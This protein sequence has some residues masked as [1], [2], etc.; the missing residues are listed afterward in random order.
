MS[1]HDELRAF[2]AV[3]EE[4]GFTAAAGVL[5]LSTSVVSRRV[6]SLEEG[7]GVRLLERTTRQVRATSVGLDYHGRVAPLLEALE[8]AARA[9]QDERSEPK[10]ILRVAVPAVFGRA[11]LSPVFASFHQRYPQIRVDASYSDRTVDLHGESADLAIRG[12]AAIDDNLVARKIFDFHGVCVASPEYLARR[13]TPATPEALSDH[14]CL[15]NSGLRT[16]PG[17]LFFRDGQPL[18]VDVDGP[19]R[20]DD[21]LALV[22][23]A[24]AGLG[25][26]YE[27]IFI[28]GPA[29]ARGTVVSIPFSDKPYGG[30][31]FAVYAN[32]RH[33]PMRVRVFIDH[34]LNMWQEPPWQAF[35]DDHGDTA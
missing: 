2:V 27:P 17:W 22:S 4:G 12:G 23:A 26:A 14:D 5:G 15:V 21:G 6:K 8:D 32:R 18:Q 3:V 19:F 16:M 20:C 34:L 9:A 1:S 11:Y 7:L 33:L 31:F 13:G 35:A 28:A 24:E 10:G 30:A 25:I 29:I